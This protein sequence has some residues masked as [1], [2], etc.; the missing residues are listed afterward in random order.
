[1]FS[2]CFPK[3]LGVSDFAKLIVEYIDKM[4]EAGTSAIQGVRFLQKH[5]VP[6]APFST[7][8]SLVRSFFS[9]VDNESEDQVGTSAIFVL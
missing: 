6:S 3:S 7:A 8:L 1:M 4:A 2:V 9:H 5:S